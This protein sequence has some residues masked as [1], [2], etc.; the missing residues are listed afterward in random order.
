MMT[1]WHQASC[2]QFNPWHPHVEKLAL[3]M[4]I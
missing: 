1:Q 4:E 3:I 2:P